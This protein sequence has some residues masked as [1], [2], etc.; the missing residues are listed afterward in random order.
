MPDIADLYDEDIL[1]V[2]E[3]TKELIARWSRKQNTKANLQEFAKEAH[4]LFLKAGFIVNVVWENALI[5]V[6]DLN[7]SSG[8]KQLPIDI[9]IIGRV[10][11]GHGVFEQGHVLMDHERKRHEVLRANERGEDYLGQKGKSA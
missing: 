9:E 2:G 3:I 4:D 11:A 8:M 5:M 1:K 10:D 6:P 7:S